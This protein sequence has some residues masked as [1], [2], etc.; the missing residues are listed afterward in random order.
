MKILLVEDEDR[1][2]RQIMPVIH[3]ACPQS[4]LSIAG[5]RDSALEALNGESFDLIICDLRIPPTPGSAD[6]D[7]RHGLA[8]HAYARELMPGTPI[9]FLTAFATAKNVRD[10]LSTGGTS[11]VFGVADY[12]MVQLT[13]KDDLDETGRLLLGLQTALN[14]LRSYSNVD[15][16]G[17][18]DEM[19]IR[20]V[21]SY[22]V[23]I[24]HPS[25]I[26]GYAAGLS[27]ATVGR[28]TLIADNGATA[29]IFL[30]VVDRA[31]AVDEYQR[32]NLYVP[33]RLQPGDFAPALPPIVS[34]LRTRAALVSTL[35]DADCVSMF[36][37]LRDDPSAAAEAVFRL[38][39]SLAPWQSGHQRLSTNMRQMRQARCA[40]HV[41]EGLDVDTGL[42]EL[43]V[44]VRQAVVHGDLHGENVLID[45]LGRPFLIDFG[46]LGE[47]S[48]SLDPLTLELSLLFHKDGPG[49]NTDW[50]R[51]VD[52]GAWAEL[53]RYVENSPYEDFIRACREWASACDGSD[54]VHATAYA[55]AMRQLKYDDVDPNLA[56]SIAR[57]AGNAIRD[58]RA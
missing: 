5:D 48:A 34:G 11:D 41:V 51:A 36:R 27:G 2:V 58:G 10:Q 47:G 29:R 24:Q 33:N 50:A 16:T 32:F 7:E 57:S 20:A 17:I 13:E 18:D 45:S 40:D 26:I 35:G 19:F 9:I 4:V 38:R 22:A 46:D 30:K 53:D 6:I 14:E 8:V 37:L 1:S 15:A 43:A 42:E 49:R 55:H 54:A 44:E 56:L 12:P 39:R 25:V 3:G 31:E 21:C 52:F 23:R 28:V